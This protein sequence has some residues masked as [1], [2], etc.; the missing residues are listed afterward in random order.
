MNKATIFACRRQ[1]I[2][3]HRTNCLKCSNVLTM[4]RTRMHITIHMKKN[5][6]DIL[7]TFLSILMVLKM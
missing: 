7:S 1:P 4:N 3:F 2:P 6:P 5:I